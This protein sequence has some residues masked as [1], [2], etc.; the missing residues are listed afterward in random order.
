MRS[1]FP[2]TRLGDRVGQF[3]RSRDPDYQ[4]LC[5]LS[6]RYGLPADASETLVAMRQAVAEEKQKLLSNKDIPPERLHAALDAIQAETEKAARETLGEK[7]FA[8]YS[9]TAAWLKNPGT[10]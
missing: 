8:Q 9:Q 1:Q 4:S 10:N 3:D 5:V 6:E 2:P 7:V